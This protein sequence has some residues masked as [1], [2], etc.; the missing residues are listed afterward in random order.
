MTIIEKNE[1]PKIPYEISETVITF[2]EDLELDLAEYVDDDPVHINVYR[3]RKN[4]LTTGR[5][6]I[7]YVAEIN[8]PPREYSRPE[9]E[10]QSPEPLPLDMQKITLTLWA[11]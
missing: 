8:I 6:G 2:N 3:T 9:E 11:V 5:G 1:G 7:A 10:G 4:Q